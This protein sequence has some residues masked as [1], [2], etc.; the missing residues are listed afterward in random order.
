MNAI[1]LAVAVSV[2]LGVSAPLL[3]TDLGDKA[4]ALAVSEWIK[5]KPVDVTTADGKN[6]YVVE[7]WATWCA[8][9]LQSI[10]HLTEMQKE[11]KA[12]N[13]TFIGISKE[14]RNTVKPFVDKMGNKM[15]YN[16]ALDKDGATYKAYMEAF[17]IQGIPYAFIVDQNGRIVWHDHPMASFDKAL[18]EVI[19]GKFDLA[20]ARKK[21]LVVTQIQEYLESATSRGNPEKLAQLGQQ[22]IQAGRDN[23]MAMNDLAW[24]ILTARQIVQRDLKLALQAA[25]AA[26]KATNGE[27]PSTL[28]TY[29][30]ALFENGRKLEAVK[31][32]T[33]AVELA[34]KNS[35]P[36]PIIT[37]L[38]ERLERF[39]Q[40]VD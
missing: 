39:K 27:D 7:F 18:E 32:Q 22:I 35:L 1:R 12:K 3:A 38:S 2:V 15:D 4:P 36:Q 37:E 14:E 29:A 11:F 9:C 28:D 17:G 16:V 40:E 19:T 26:N 13:V 5:G 21:K 23:P 31:T 34:R 6:V 25:E 20:T 24:Q 33:R 30:L 10:P 8:P